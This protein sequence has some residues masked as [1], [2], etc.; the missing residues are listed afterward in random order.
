MDKFRDQ[1]VVEANL[2]Q[3]LQAIE[4]FCRKHMFLSGDQDDFNSRNELTVPTKVIR[5]AS[6]NSILCKGLHKTAYVK[7]DIMSRTFIS[8]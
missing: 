8:A 5:E 6:L 4:D 3:Q 1:A 2:F 7:S